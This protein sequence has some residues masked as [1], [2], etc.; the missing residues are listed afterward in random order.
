MRQR[1][2]ADRGIRERDAFLCAGRAGAVLQKGDAIVGFDH[3]QRRQ[4]HAARFR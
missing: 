2:F 1:L 4:R 3:L